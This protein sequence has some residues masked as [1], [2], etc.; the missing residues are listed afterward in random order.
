MLCLVAGGFG[1]AAVVAA[2]AIHGRPVLSPWL[3]LGTLPTWIGLWATS[4]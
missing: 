3:L 2:L 1:L 4:R